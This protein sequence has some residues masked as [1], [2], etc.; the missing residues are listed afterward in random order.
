MLDWAL[1][2]LRRTEELDDDAF[3]DEGGE[4]YDMD[5]SQRAQMESGVQSIQAILG[6][7][8]G[9][10]ESEIREALWNFYF[11]VDQ[12]VEALLGE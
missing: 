12:S 4:D 1:K 6:A 5:D 3:S 9:I 7:Q 2:S 8:A 11:D 10:P